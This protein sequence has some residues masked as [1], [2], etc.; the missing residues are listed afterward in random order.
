MLIPLQ[1]GVQ[2]GLINV[3]GYVLLLGGLFLT[4]VWWRVLYR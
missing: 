3:A 4:A 2:A 1:E